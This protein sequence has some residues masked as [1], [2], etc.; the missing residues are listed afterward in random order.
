MIKALPTLV[1]TVV[2][3]GSPRCLLY[4]SFVDDFV[5]QSA[6]A[7]SPSRVGIR[8]RQASD[9]SNQSGRPS[10]L[11]AAL[12]GGAP[13]PTGEGRCEGVRVGESCAAGRCPPCCTV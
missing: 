4:P 13:S 2:R 6:A 5:G 3:K 12:A 11:D 1:A 9:V 7:G 10:S 8:V